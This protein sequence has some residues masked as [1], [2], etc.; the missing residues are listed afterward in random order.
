L[1]YYFPN[2]YVGG[3]FGAIN[4]SAY[5]PN[6]FSPNISGSIGYIFPQ[7]WNKKKVRLGLNW[8]NGRSWSNQFF[9]RKEKFVAFFVEADL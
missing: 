4:V 8:Y 7:E 6:A 3:V 9:N 2:K 1:E 5:Q